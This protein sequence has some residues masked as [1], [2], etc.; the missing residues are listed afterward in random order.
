VGPDLAHHFR[1]QAAKPLRGNV[2][3]APAGQAGGLVF[4]VMLDAGKS[5]QF[6][7]GSVSSLVGKMADRVS[8][9]T[10]QAGVLLAE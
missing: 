7:A 8:D 1:G 10:E 6:L 9:H 2:P 5:G 3:V 4:D